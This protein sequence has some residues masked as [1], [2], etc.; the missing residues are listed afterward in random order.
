[1]NDWEKKDLEAIRGLQVG[2][3]AYVNWF[4]EGGGEVV[5]RGDLY[6]LYEIPQYG[7]EGNFEKT[8]SYA[9]LEELVKYVHKTYI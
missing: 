9:E 8:Y 5:R 4:E 2:E 6:Y 1:M 3:T 7:G